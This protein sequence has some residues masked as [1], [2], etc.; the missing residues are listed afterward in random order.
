MGYRNYSAARGHI[1]AQDGSGD[2]STIGAAIAAA[3][4]GQTIF[5]RP[6]TYTENV[7]LVAGVNLSAFD[8]DS[9]NVV[10][11]TAANVIINGTVTAS[12]TGTC[13][14]SGICLQTN[15]G[16]CFTWTGNN[17]TGVRFFNCYFSGLNS[18]AIT[19]NNPN[20]I[21]DI[22]YCFTQANGSNPVFN[23]TNCSSINFRH[24]IM[25]AGSKSVVSTINGGLC[26]MYNCEVEFALATTGAGNYTIRN[27]TIASNT[28]VSLA[29][30]GTGTSSAHNSFFDATGNSGSSAAIT[31]G[32]GTTLN[33]GQC[34]VASNAGGA[35]A[36][37]SGAGTINAGAL[38]FTGSSFINTVT[39]NTFLY[40]G[41]SNTYT[42]VLAFGGASVGITYATQ[43]G[44]Y[45]TVGK[46]VYVDLTIILSSKGSS[47][48]NASITLPFTANSTIASTLVVQTNANTFPSG[49]TYVTA[50]VGAS[51]TTCSLTGSG[52][53]TNT[54]LAD[55]NF[56]NSTT[57]RISGSYISA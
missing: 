6:G 51:G 48:G 19:G 10:G 37:I 35:S 2:F 39:T 27:S 32:T 17:N 53:A 57:V 49:A 15:A 36:A 52:A 18:T 8:C 25:F 47:S 26:N 21:M 46:L 24:C 16:A 22:H 43:S 55:T 29:L 31:V 38:T 30:V 28:S 45:Y 41:Y 20:A 1:V 11:G 4:P 9:S 7:T 42:P 40:N 13:T 3:S 33:I 56:A 14:L 50:F 44:I 23:I 12:F 5:I 54:A 34:V